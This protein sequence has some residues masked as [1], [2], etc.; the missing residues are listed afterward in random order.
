MDDRT[1]EDWEDGFSS[2]FDRMVV[3]DHE[4]GEYEICCNDQPNSNQ[5]PS[6]ITTSDEKHLKEAHSLSTFSRPWKI[7]KEFSKLGS[8][9]S[10][11]SPVQV[12]SKAYS[13][14]EPTPAAPS[15]IVVASLPTTGKVPFFCRKRQASSPM[16]APP[17]PQ[18]A[19]ANA[20]GPPAPTAANSKWRR[21][22]QEREGLLYVGRL[23]LVLLALLS[24]GFVLPFIFTLKLFCHFQTHCYSDE[25]PS[26]L[27]PWLYN[28]KFSIFPAPFIIMY[29]CRLC[30][31]QRVSDK[32][33]RLHSHLNPTRP[34]PLE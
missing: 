22:L 14:G 10:K 21:F 27:F 4:T 2:R 16:P 24:P 33:F 13:S 5:A 9:T 19:T 32:I 12:C 23:L 1:G 25:C 20:T 8:T 34:K 6:V 30:R 29:Q 7:P 18:E 31:D 3:H 26:D 28:K 15:A 11:L 17:K